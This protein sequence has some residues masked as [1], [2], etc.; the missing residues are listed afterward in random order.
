MCAPDY[1]ATYFTLE[2]TLTSTVHFQTHFL[3]L[4]QACARL[5]TVAHVTK[6]TSSV[7]QAA[8]RS[9]TAARLAA[10]ALLLGSVGAA[11]ASMAAASTGA[12]NVGQV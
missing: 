8:S 1:S 11:P 9:V 4:L 10:A 5:T 3:L 2:Y 12:V 6:D 7:L